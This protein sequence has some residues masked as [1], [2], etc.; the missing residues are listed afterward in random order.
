MY[1][2]HLQLVDYRSYAAARL[3]L[4]PGVTTFVGS[5]GQGKTNLLEA[6]GYAATLSSHRVSTDA[7]LVRRG[8][9]RAVVRAA[10]FADERRSLIEI[11][12]NPGRANRAR[13]NRSV[14]PRV[15]DVLGTLRTV[16][17]APE[18]LAL[19]KGDP[20]ERRKYLDE[21]LT[22]RAPRFAAVRAD[23][24][25]VLKQ[26]NALLKTAAQVSG[27]ARPDLSTLDV[28]DGHLAETGAALVAGRLG[29]VAE[30][31]PLV[32][33]AY[34][35]LADSGGFPELRYRDSSVAE[36][37]ESTEAVGDQGDTDVTAIAQRLRDALDRA[38]PEEL[39]RG[40]SLVG[41]HRDD[42]LLSLDE[43]AVKGYASQGESWSYG[44]SLKLSAFELLRADGEDPV[45]IL[46]DVFSELDAARRQRLAQ[47]VRDAEQVLVSAAV[48]EDLPS[49][50]RGE[51]YQ[52]SEGTVEHV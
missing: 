12:I 22:L 32:A 48:P 50:L 8:A 19:V 25:R 2:S 43:F 45:L 17:F 46:D 3:E 42:L 6:I 1:V 30:L 41:P 47:H 44:L 14:L 29:L 13:L 31:R 5:N 33:K 7:P 26:R 37:P 21:L 40:V 38:R 52:V 35:Q 39:R 10:S 9:E 4:A 24:E 18:D 27:R 11:E 51:R 36:A 23:Y 20:G 49:D 16:L 15:R 28:W 34:A